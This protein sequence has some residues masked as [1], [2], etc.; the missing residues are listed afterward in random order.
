MLTNSNQENNT[1]F[2]DFNE[3]I[4]FA[5][6]IILLVVIPCILQ[7]KQTSAFLQGLQL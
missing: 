1:N 7:E 4:I 2:I 5:V 3:I 6:K